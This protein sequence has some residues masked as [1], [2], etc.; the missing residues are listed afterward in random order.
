[1]ANTYSVDPNNERLTAITT[2]ETAA[3]D[4]NA[5]FYKDAIAE[6]QNEINKQIAASKNWANTQTALQNQQT[7]F[8]IEKIEQQKEQAKKDYT[9]EQSGAYVDWQKQSN[10][11]GVNAEQQAA[12]GMANTGYSESSQ[13]SLYNTYQNRIVAA[14]QSYDQAILNYNN[15]ITE[16]KLQNSSI[17]AEIAY[18]SLQTQLNLSLQ[19]VQYKNQLLSE[20]ADK[21]LQIQSLYDTKYQQVYSNIFNEI[22]LAE[23]A[24]QF[25][26]TKKMQEEQFKKSYEL[27][28]AELAEKKRQFDKEY[29]LKYAATGGGSGGSTK[30][31]KGSSGGSSKS[32]SKS[33][34]SSTKASKT[35]VWASGST[36]AK[37]S[38]NATID[39]KSVLALGRGPISGKTLAK[40]EDEGKV[41]SRT[42]GN[43]IVFTPTIKG[44]YIK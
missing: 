22:K 36:K 25:D 10:E 3:L 31:S 24:R 41:T 17:L 38:G 23:D 32:S 37:T 11:Y 43:K 39:T 21:K 20:M 26:V 18:E 44:K 12:M 28:Q 27:Q 29:A 13:V 15:A 19:G 6:N 1:M 4:K 2:Q 42:V 8:A 33:S 9:K 5:D 35:Q 14:K 40:L 30:S 7:D 34:S 16:A